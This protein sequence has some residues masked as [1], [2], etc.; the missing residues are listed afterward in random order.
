MHKSEVS[1]DHIK[2]VSLYPHLRFDE[3]NVRVT[4]IKCNSDRND[5]FDPKEY[6][7]NLKIRKA[8]KHEERN[9]VSD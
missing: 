3:N 5:S 9:T 6:A 1:L 7:V 4:H 2:P 8:N